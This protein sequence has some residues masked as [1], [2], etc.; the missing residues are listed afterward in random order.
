MLLDAEVRAG[1]HGGEWR[2]RETCERARFTRGALA[3]G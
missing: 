3:T 2:G 1:A